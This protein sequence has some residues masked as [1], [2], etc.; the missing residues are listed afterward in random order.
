MKPCLSWIRISPSISY[1]NILLLP[2]AGCNLKWDRY[3]TVFIAYKDNQLIW[4]YRFPILYHQGQQSVLLGDLRNHQ[5]LEIQKQEILHPS[6]L[7]CYH[8]SMT[9]VVIDVFCDQCLLLDVLSFISSHQIKNIYES[10]T[11]IQF[12][13]DFP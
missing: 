5:H 9:F 8:E 7:L 3:N 11:M 13:E 4:I 12:L 2:L 6:W 10:L 1:L